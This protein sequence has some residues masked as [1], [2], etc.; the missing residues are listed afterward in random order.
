MEAGD[1]WCSWPPSWSTFSSPAPS[2][3]LGCY[4]SNSSTYLTRHRRQL[5]G[6]RRFVTSCTVR[7]VRNA[8]PSFIS[9]SRVHSFFQTPLSG[10]IP[11]KGFVFLQLVPVSRL[12]KPRLNIQVCLSL[13]LPCLIGTSKLRAM[14]LHQFD[15]SFHDTFMKERV[16]GKR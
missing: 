15:Y 1:G 10:R 3:P 2:S 5:H 11:V 4:S 8:A 7:Q 13:C 9:R 12:R 14:R 6:Y 16:I